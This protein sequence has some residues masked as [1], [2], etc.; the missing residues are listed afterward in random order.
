[1]SLDLSTLDDAL[2]LSPDELSIEAKVFFALL[3]SREGH[4]G[5]RDDGG[6]VQGSTLGSCVSFSRAFLL[7]LLISLFCRQAFT[8]LVS[9]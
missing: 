5:R 6:G 9:H 4:V 7:P 1:M 8:Y 2:G 3:L